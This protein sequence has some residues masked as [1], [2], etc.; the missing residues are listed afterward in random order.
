MLYWQDSVAFSAESLI[1]RYVCYMSY[2]L[3]TA[4]MSATDPAACVQMV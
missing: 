4:C 3:E 1:D 2:K